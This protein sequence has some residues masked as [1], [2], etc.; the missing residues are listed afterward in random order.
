M[1]EILDKSFF[2]V[3]EASQFLGVPL[4]GGIT[5]IYTPELIKADRK[6][7]VLKVL[8]MTLVGVLLVLISIKIRV[9]MKV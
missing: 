7:N 8:S 4:L 2:D 5:K 3:Q 9:L 1:Y 6:K